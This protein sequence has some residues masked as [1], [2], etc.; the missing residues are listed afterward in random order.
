M[1]LGR[2]RGEM[3]RLGFIEVWDVCM[4]GFERLL[5]RFFFKEEW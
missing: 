3:C 5:E 2:R 4:E 1:G